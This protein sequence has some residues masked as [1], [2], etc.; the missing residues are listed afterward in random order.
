MFKPSTKRKAALK[1]RRLFYVGAPCSMCGHRKRY[2]SN[3]ACVTCRK[4][5]V[6]DKYDSAPALIAARGYEAARKAARRGL[7][8]E[9]DIAET[10]T[11]WAALV[12]LL[13]ERN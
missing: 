12:R 13:T 6:L 11:L 3:R 7:Q 9:A 2:T 10:R 8:R 5:E 4:Q 1:A